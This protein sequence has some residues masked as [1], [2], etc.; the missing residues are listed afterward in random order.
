MSKPNEPAGRVL[1]WEPDEWRRLSLAGHV[2]KPNEP[3][4]R[5]L[6]W[7]P[8]EWRRVGHPKITLKKTLEDDTGLEAHEFQT[9]MLD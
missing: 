1:L 8:D 5:V 3:A 2:S 7:E 6:L 9:V 4:G